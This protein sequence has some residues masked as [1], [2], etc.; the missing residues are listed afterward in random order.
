MKKLL[1]ILFINFI[2]IFSQAPSRDISLSFSLGGGL[3]SEIS[4]KIYSIMDSRVEY[5]TYTPNLSGMIGLKYESVT[6]IHNLD[7][8]VEFQLGYLASSTS[9]SK[10]NPYSGKLKQ[11]LIPVTI[12]VILSNKDILSP[13]LKLGLGIGNKQYIEEYK[14]YTSANITMSK[15]F[16]ILNGGT[17]LT[18]KLEDYINISFILESFIFNGEVS[19]KSDIGFHRVVEGIQWN[20]YIGL[21]FSYSL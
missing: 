3:A 1:F 11:R 5:L 12:S 4:G 20:S 13:Y 10:F 7:L 15:W 9:Y 8:G 14:D 17:G 19:G 21:Q 6:K 18:F 2:Q 16:L